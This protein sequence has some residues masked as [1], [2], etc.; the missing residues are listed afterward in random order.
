[1]LRYLSF[2]LIFIHNQVSI[3]AKTTSACGVPVVSDRIVGGTDSKKG[4]W[5]WQIS[6]TYKNDFLCGGSLIADSWVLT[7]AHCFD[8]LEV[9]YYNVYL[10]AHQLSALGNSTVTRGVK[11]IIKHP[12]FQYEGS[13]GDIA[14]IEL[15]KPVTFTPY[16]LPVCLPSHNVQFAA[17]SMCWVTG[18]GNIQAGA[19]LSSPKT[20]QKAEVGII[21]RS[22]CETMYKSSLGYST[23]V[24]FIQKDMVCAGYK[25]GQVDACQ[26]DSGGPLVFNVNNVWLQLGIVSWG[27]GCAEPDRPGVYTKVQFYQDWLKTNVP[28]L[29]FSEGGPSAGS[30]GVAS[31]TMSET[32]SM[33]MS[34]SIAFSLS[35]STISTVLGVNETKTIDNEAQI[36]SCSLFTVA[37]NFF[38]YLSIRFFA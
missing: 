23:G 38:I 13:S 18:W 19:P 14:L 29:M 34:N 31:T 6:L 17:G 7:A 30:S 28:L 25:E 32:E 1:M 20:L 8:S 21:D 10:G 33:T 11:R 27:F 15:E 4:E 9:S 26:G 2:L 35:P 3:V 24:D 16:I 37:L 22:S 12:D 36:H 5:P